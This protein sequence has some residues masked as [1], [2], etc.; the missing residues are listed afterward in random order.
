MLKCKQ[1]NFCSINRYGQTGTGKTFTMEGEHALLNSNDIA[2]T[3]ENDPLVGIIPRSVSHL[4]SILNSISNCEFS[5]K[6]SF[7]ELYNEELSDL[8]SDSSSEKE[9]K[10]RIYDDPLRKGSVAIPGLQ[11]C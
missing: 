4:F 10:L 6:I 3:W 5:V 9:E 1:V 8:L 7:I 11:V 2:A